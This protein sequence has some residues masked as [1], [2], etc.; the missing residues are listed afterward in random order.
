MN[1]ENWQELWLK[2]PSPAAG[3]ENMEETIARVRAG[4]KSFDRTVLWRD[5][6]EGVAALG[7]S[8]VFGMVAMAKINEGAF[9]W[10]VILAAVLPLGVAGFLL[11]DRLR[12]RGRRPGGGGTV[13]AE[14]DHAIAELQHQHRLLTNV[15]WW[16]L[17]PLAASGGLIMVHAA[18]VA[19][20]L[21]WARLLVLC[22]ALAIILLVNVPIYRL[23]MRVARD[24]LLPRIEEL[25]RR[26][27]AFMDGE[28]E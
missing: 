16:Y 2:Q 22:V 23:N 15:L 8:A 20:P 5:V 10:D 25:E 26:R 28:A 19:S 12:A 7:V 6:R 4:A 1:F 21:W 24:E 11:V 18:M 14:L 3:A 17:L 13:I 9:A 27:R